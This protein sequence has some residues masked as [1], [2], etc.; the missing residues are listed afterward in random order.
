M[1]NGCRKQRIERRREDRRAFQRNTEVRFT[2]TKNGSAYLTEKAAIANASEHGVSVRTQGISEADVALILSSPGKCTMAFSPPLP[3]GV[4]FLAGETVWFRC[5]ESD[6]QPEIQF[7]VRLN[8]TVPA[9]RSC[10]AR[11]L[12]GSTGAGGGAT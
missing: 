9:E 10:L 4:S 12:N 11:C 3:C 1:T 5:V 7:G 2:L 8:N 6:S